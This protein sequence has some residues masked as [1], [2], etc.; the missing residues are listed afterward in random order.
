LKKGK[1]GKGKRVRTVEGPRKKVLMKRGRLK[2]VWSHLA[3]HRTILGYH[4]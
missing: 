3:G 4:E 1:D 2:R